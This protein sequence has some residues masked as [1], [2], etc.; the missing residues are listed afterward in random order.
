[1]IIKASK[2]QKEYIR[3]NYVPW[4]IYPFAFFSK[5]GRA[6]FAEDGK[7]TTISHDLEK[8]GSTP[9]IELV[10]LTS[11]LTYSSAVLLA[12]TF[13]CYSNAILVGEETGG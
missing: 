5:I 1:M 12:N 3:E 2:T 8:A 7:F 9:N 13:N 10:I 4:Y 6:T 11:N